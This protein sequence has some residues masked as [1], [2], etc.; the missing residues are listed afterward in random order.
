M[1]SQV[2]EYAKVTDVQVTVRTVMLFFISIA[3]PVKLSISLDR[4]MPGSQWALEPKSP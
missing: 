4:S 1:F 2:F 3:K